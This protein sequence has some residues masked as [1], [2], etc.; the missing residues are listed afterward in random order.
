MFSDG[1]EMDSDS[2]ESLDCA[3]GPQSWV[4][5]WL[6]SAGCRPGRQRARCCHRRAVRACLLGA[7]PKAPCLPGERVLGPWRWPGLQSGSHQP[8]CGEPWLVLM[9]RMIKGLRT[10]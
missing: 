3:L 7:G 1:G 4:G 5:P 10:P 2:R 9:A 8:S 6:W